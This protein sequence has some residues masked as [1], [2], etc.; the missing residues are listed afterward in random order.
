MA[1]CHLCGR[2]FRSLGSHLR[3]HGMTADQYHQQYGLLRR[4]ARSARQLT[5][6]RSTAQ[7]QAYT[8]SERMRTEAYTAFERMRTDFAQ[9]QTMARNGALSRRSRA[10]FTEHGVSQELER[11][12]LERLAAG[13]RTQQAT[14][15][16]HLTATIEALGFPSVEAAL[17]TLYMEHELSIENTAVQIAMSPKRARRLLARYA[18][19]IRAT[20]QNTAS[21]RRTRI[22]LNDQRTAERLGTSDIT[23][24]LRT[25]RASPR[26]DRATCTPR[27]PAPAGAE[28]ARTP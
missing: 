16:Q 12:R 19:P 20:G 27:A 21:G 1:I 4:R 24:W 5:Q 22:A 11:E 17:R 23:G 10:A 3:A 8:A 14:A 2:G 25:R 15:E 7:R 13:R 9:G 18:I 28:S 26:A 6:A